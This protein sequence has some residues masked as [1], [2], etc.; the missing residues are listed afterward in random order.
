MD[1]S[2]IIYK[3]IIEDSKNK[4]ITYYIP[5]IEYKLTNFV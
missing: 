3:L 2:T 1:E 5:C 4:I